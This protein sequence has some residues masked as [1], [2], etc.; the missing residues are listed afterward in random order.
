MGVSHTTGS[1]T[2]AA[3]PSGQSVSVDSVTVGHGE[4]TVTLIRGTPPESDG[5]YD[6]GHF[7]VEVRATGLCATRPVFVYGWSDVAGFFSDLAENW[8]GW[9]GPKTWTSPE[10][11][12]TMTATH[13]S[14]SHVTIE[15][16]VR[17]GPVHTWSATTAVD[18]EP[19]EEM[20]HLAKQVAELIPTTKP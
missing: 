5:S 4:R 8:R 2:Q 11:D 3:G 7:G 17:D 1:V 18:V 6:G 14:S 16:V 13:K 9:V 15:F 12:L 19:G 10:Y 20:T